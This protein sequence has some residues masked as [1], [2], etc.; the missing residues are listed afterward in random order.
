MKLKTKDVVFVVIQCLL[1]IVY[2]F[3]INL[4]KF[5]SHYIIS[6]IAIGLIIIGILLSGTSL[7]LLNKNL[8]PFPSPKLNSVLV[9]RSI[10]NYIRHPIYTG[11]VLSFFGYAIYYGSAYKVLVSTLLLL[12]FY[13]KSNYEEKQLLKK[14]KNYNTYIKTTGRFFPKI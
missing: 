3:K 13:L 4:C 7:V 2:F 14:F 5:N 9:T 6:M 12:L 8:S 1:F 11:I 10:Y